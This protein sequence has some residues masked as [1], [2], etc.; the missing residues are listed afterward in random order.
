ML[1]CGSGIDDVDDVELD[2]KLLEPL[3]PASPHKKQKLSY[4]DM[5]HALSLDEAMFFPLDPCSCVRIISIINGVLFILVAAKK[6][7]G[8]E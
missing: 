2:D 8:W 7:F 4:W 1:L 3:L 6:Q 5:Y